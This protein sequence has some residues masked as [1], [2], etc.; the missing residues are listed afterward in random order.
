[1][2][3]RISDSGRIFL[4]HQVAQV[5]YTDH[6]IEIPIHKQVHNL[7]TIPSLCAIR[8]CAGGAKDEDTCR[9]VYL[10]AWRRMTNV[11]VPRAF[12]SSYLRN[13]P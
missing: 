5:E 1:M 7:G 11:V 2:T 6:H 4:P 12:N 3:T 9:R 13:I 8:L 10:R